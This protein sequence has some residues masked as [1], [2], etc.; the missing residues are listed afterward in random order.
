[1]T[2]GDGRVDR[3]VAPLET[4]GDKQ[5]IE[6]Q[7]EEESGPV[8][9]SRSPAQP[10][11]KQEEEHRIDHYPYRSWCKFCVMGRGIGF[12]HR[13]AGVSRVPRIGIDYFFITASG[14]KKREE[15]KE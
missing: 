2:D 10:T 3:V 4:A 8:K 6:I 7:D 1:M 14:V 15:L 13:H 12:Q 5:E 11:A 9:I